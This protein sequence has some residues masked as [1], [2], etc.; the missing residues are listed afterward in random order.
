MQQLNMTGLREQLESRSE[1]ELKAMLQTELDRDVPDPDAVRLILNVLENRRME[2]SDEPTP[3]RKAAWQRYQQRVSALK[4]K[5]SGNSRWIVRAASLILIA[6]LLFVV[7]PQQAEAETFWQML[8]QWTES[9]MSF[10]GREDWIAEPEYVFRTE[11]DGL[12]QVYDAVVELGVT[13]PVVP[14]WLPGGY[15][16]VSLDGV[17]TP[18]LTGIWATFSDGESECVYKLDCYSGEA[19]HQFY[20]D[21]IH[22][23]SYELEGT[24]YNITQNDKWWVVVWGKDNIECF[25][26]LDCQEDDLRRMLDSIYVMED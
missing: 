3:G 22:A 20:R 4:Q 11:N 19:T 25:I 10:F 26:T 6:G 16:L 2:T 14:M 13:E 5:R 21:D 17:T 15:K 8:Q 12:Q 24:I 7:V 18:M 9:V 23:E 1:D